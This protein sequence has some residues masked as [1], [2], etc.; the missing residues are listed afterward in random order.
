M[1]A[2]AQAGLAPTEGLA[3]VGGWG[4]LKAAAQ[5]GSLGGAALDAQ[6]NS[7]SAKKG[8]KVAAD[9]KQV[10]KAR[11]YKEACCEFRK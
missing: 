7:R 4:A 6:S 8:K 3:S 9:P 1:K 11:L 10:L 5:A 2:A